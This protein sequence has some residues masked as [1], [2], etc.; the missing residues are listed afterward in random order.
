MRIQSPL[1]R[2]RGLATIVVALVLLVGISIVS[3]FANRVTL[4]DLRMADN[5]YKAGK[6]FQAAEAGLERAIARMQDKAW[7]DA[8]F[9]DGNSD[10]VMPDAPATETLGTDQTHR[11]TFTRLG[12]D[13]KTLRID[14]RG[15][16]DACSPCTASCAGNALVAHILQFKPS[17]AGVPSAPMTAKGNVQTGGNADIVNTDPS[18]NGLTVLAG[19]NTLSVGSATLTSLPGTPPGASVAMNDTTLSSLSDD[20][21]F[22]EFFGDTK[23]NVQAAAHQVTCSGVC[24]AS[25]SGQTGKVIYVTGNTQISSNITIGSTASPVILIVDGTLHITGNVEIYG[26][27]YCT[28]IIWDNTGMGTVNIHG[29]A[30]AEGSFTGNGTPT[31]TYD[32]TVMDNLHDALGT[33]AKVIGSWRDF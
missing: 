16:S 2:Q 9:I 10:G 5:Q 31:I 19:G 18:T 26:I 3:L 21:F 25:L 33:Y 13:N 28:A 23:A 8:N 20:Q 7:R 24:N 32:K 4:F 27:V 1:H 14:S 17:L 6:A 15:C 12:G 30:V 22:M 29:G 11:V